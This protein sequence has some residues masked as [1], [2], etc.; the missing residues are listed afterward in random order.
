MGLKV[1]GTG[2]NSFVTFQLLVKQFISSTN[3]IQTV[4]GIYQVSIIPYP[5]CIAYKHDTVHEI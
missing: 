1:I 5:L 2:T 4:P 3:C